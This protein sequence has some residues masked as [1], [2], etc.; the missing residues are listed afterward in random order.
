MKLLKLSHKTLD[1]STAVHLWVY[2][3]KNFLPT[4]INVMATLALLSLKND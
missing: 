4:E 2:P 1:R 3:P